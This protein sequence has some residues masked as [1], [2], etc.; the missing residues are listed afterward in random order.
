M[1]NVN[2][3]NV[4]FKNF[5]RKLMYVIDLCHNFATEKERKRSLRIKILLNQKENKKN[6]H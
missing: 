5:D 3:Y 1:Y 4:K 6:Y 2:V